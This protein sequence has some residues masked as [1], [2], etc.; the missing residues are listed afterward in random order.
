MHGATCI[1]PSNALTNV[2][3]MRG[4]DARPRAHHRLC[5]RRPRQLPQ[6]AETS[7]AVVVLKQETVI[8]LFH[9]EERVGIKTVRAVCR[10]APTNGNYVSSDGPTSFTAGDG[11]GIPNIRFFLGE[12]ST[13]VNEMIPNHKLCHDVPDKLSATKPNEWPQ[14][15]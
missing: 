9:N 14:M 2:V 11:C 10:G 13:S 12:L 15:R 5:R 1:N 3:N 6:D 8:I 4:N 7:D